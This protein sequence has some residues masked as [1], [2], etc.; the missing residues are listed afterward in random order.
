MM[1]KENLIDQKLMALKRKAGVETDAELAFHLG[2]RAD[3]LREII[4]DMIFDDT[5]LD[6][7]TFYAR[8]YSGSIARLFALSIAHYLFAFAVMYVVSV[9]ASKPINL[10]PA[11]TGTSIFLFCAIL[12]G[13]WVRRHRNTY[14]G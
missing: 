1:S 4:H 9:L 2:C 3:E 12:L 6:I 5:P 11:V 13:G 14:V 7:L 10:L 8:Y